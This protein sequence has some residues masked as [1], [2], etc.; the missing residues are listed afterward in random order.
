MTRLNWELI[1]RNV[2]EARAQL[3]KLEIYLNESPRRSEIQLKADLE[4]A[5]HHLNFAWNARRIRYS[6]YSN[7][8]DAD[9]NDWGKFPTD[10]EEFTIEERSKR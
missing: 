3:E 1:R 6:R 8:S 2:T 5:F 10:F 9:F 7:L 4:H